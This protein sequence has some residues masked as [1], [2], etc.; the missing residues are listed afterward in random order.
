[1][2]R[3]DAPRSHEQE[4]IEFFLLGAGFS[5]AVS[6]AMPTLAELQV[7]VLARLGLSEDVLAPFGR[8]LEQWLS[9]LAVDQPWL[10]DSENLRNRATFA[11]ASLAVHDSIRAAESAAT[12]AAPEDWLARLAW[13]WCDRRAAVATFNYDVLVER[14][15]TEL[16]R[17]GTW[18][19]L[20]GMSLAERMPPGS[21]RFLSSNPPVGDVLTLY[22]LHGSVNWLYGGM[23]A[24]VSDRV[25]LAERSQRWEAQAQTQRD[26]GERWRAVYDDLVPLIIPPTG[27]KS[28]YYGNLSL[29]AQ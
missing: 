25:V 24:P 17:A 21:S 15:A 26:E 14:M 10:T 19:D 20:Y 1:M 3:S 7:D 5:K 11:E 9:Y 12:G 13:D 29:R 18:S 6:V 23:H 22:K 27:T 16:G 28:G 4:P 2:T 8:N